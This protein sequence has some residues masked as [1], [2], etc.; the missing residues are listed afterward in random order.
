VRAAAI[1][2]PP[3]EAKRALESRL[4]ETVRQLAVGLELLHRKGMV[5]RDLKPSNVL[6]TAKGRVVI[7]DFGLVGS[8]APGLRS[9]GQDVVG[10]AAYMAPEQARTSLVAPAADMYSVGVMMYEALSGALPFDGTGVEMLMNKQQEDA[11]AL[12]IRGDLAE[13]CRDLLARNAETRPTA[14]AVAAR[15]ASRATTEERPAPLVGRADEIRELDAALDEVAAGAAITVLVEG[16]SGIGKSSLVRSFLEQVETTRRPLILTG[17]CYER[18]SVPFKGID[19]VVDS[20]AHELLRRNPVDVA[21][22]LTDEVEALA[23][24]F[25]VL[26]RVPAIARMRVWRPTSPVELRSRAFRGLRELI[27]TL[28]A[29]SPVVIAIDDLQWA[30]TD[31]LALLRE[32]VHPPNAPSVLV[33]ATWRRDA[34]TPPDL[35]GDVRA[36]ELAPLSA[37]EGRQLIAMLAPDREAEAEALI[38]EAGGHPMFLHELARHVTG[39]RT[40]SSR[41]DDALWARVL[42]MEHQARR[43]LELVAV[44]G[45]PVQQGVVGQALELEPPT[46]TKLLGELRGSSLVRTGGTRAMDLVEPYHDRVREAIAA[47]VPEPRRRRYHE[48]LADVLLASKHGDLDPLAA[49]RHLEAA[50]AVQ[51]AGELAMQAAPRAEEKLAFELAAALWEAALRLGTH[52]DDERRALLMRRAEALSHAGRGPDSA[53]AFLAAALGASAETGFQCRRRAAHE[54]LVSGHVQDG[55][56]LT[57]QALAELGEHLPSSTSAAKR[58]LIWEWTKLAVRGTKFRER[59][60]SAR[61]GLD[62][63][64]LDMMRSASIGLSMVDL[65]PSAAFQARSVLLAL[66]MG[67]RRRI[68]Y[69]LAFHAMFVASRG[70]LIPRARALVAQSREIATELGSDFLLAWSRAGEGIT[71][72]FAGHHVEALALLDDAERRLREVSVGAHAEVNHLRTFILFTLRRLGAY[73]ELRDRLVTYK[74]DA[75]LRGDRYAATSHVWSSNGVWLAAD[76][77]DRA[78]HELDSVTWS[79]PADGLHLQHWFLIRSRSELALYEDDM[80]QIEALDPLLRPFL[81]PAFAHVEAV[82]TETRYVLARFAIRRGDPAA[83]HREIRPIAGIKAPYI[84]AFVRLVQAA[85]AARQGRADLARDH[86]AGAIGDADAC[87]MAAVAA[88]GRLRTAELAGDAAA[89][90]DARAVL[91]RCGVVDCE[92]FARVFATW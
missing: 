24:V 31:S 88:L 14:A 9:A 6:V 48:R 54:L 77:V 91:A 1:G 83:A 69:A 25:P 65:V 61:T 52:A 28:A 29:T 34:G 37:A 43:V 18:E 82:A 57:K 73:T 58:Q 79:D 78:R 85:V 22:L 10:T 41:F 44:A 4:R 63:L 7:L 19:G 2:V 32:I 81:G 74:Q 76:D 5:H 92:R 27:A 45:A 30:D 84:R 80:A 20:L 87:K 11:P 89:I 66:R 13:L 50:G 56:A 59:P 46:L 51:H 17:R 67:D 12:A 72:F 49:I 62:E 71:E 75:R 90:D 36:I 40:T 70:V 38:G 35:P 42:R 55:L 21:L 86:L 47:R 33:I 60:T 53:Q 3:H 39:T 16:E 23:R 64:R 8:A 26:R 68:A 15:L